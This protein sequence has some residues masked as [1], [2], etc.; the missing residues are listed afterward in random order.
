MNG[1]DDGSRRARACGEGSAWASGNGRSYSRRRARSFVYVSR[2]GSKRFP[3]SRRPKP[4]ISLIVGS[5][6]RRCILPRGVFTSRATIGWCVE[7]RS[8]SRDPRRVCIPP[9]SY[10]KNTKE[11]NTSSTSEIPRPARAEVRSGE[12]PL[13]PAQARSLAS[14]LPLAFEFE[15]PEPLTPGT[16]HVPF[17]RARRWRRGVPPFE[18]RGSLWRRRRRRR[19]TRRSFL[20]R[21]PT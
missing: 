15:R 4:T 10:P 3:Y 16:S 20:R 19:G 11:K 8:A 12:G 14:H 17:I 13:R 9:R 18:R 7:N 5:S 2:D 1:R 6:S 21:R